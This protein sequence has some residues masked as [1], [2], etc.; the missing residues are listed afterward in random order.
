MKSAARILLAVEDPSQRARLERRLLRRG[1]HV[2]PVSER[3]D[4][5]AS[6]FGLFA[7]TATGDGPVLLLC[8]VAAWASGDVRAAALVGRP[9]RAQA[10]SVLEGGGRAGLGPSLPPVLRLVR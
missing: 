2:I 6:L 7:E 10:L 3:G 4:T 1:H 8:D 5:L 9:W